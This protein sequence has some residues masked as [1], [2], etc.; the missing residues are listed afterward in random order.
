[1]CPKW[2]TKAAKTR[3]Q[4]KQQQKSEARTVFQTSKFSNEPRGRLGW[5]GV[6]P[7]ASVIGWREPDESVAVDEEAC[8]RA[9]EA[10]GIVR[11]LGSGVLPLKAAL[12]NAA[13]E[14]FEIIRRTMARKD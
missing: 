13:S 11:T 5:G 10:A 2:S 8:A 6:C 7:G 12:E 3:Q 4:I 1:M 14:P 9:G